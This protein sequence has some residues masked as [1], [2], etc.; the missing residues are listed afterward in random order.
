[1]EPSKVLPQQKSQIKKT[2]QATPQLADLIRAHETYHPHGKEP[3]PKP[4]PPKPLPPTGTPPYTPGKP[5]AQVSDQHSL[6]KVQSLVNFEKPKSAID[7][8]IDQWLMQRRLRGL[9]T[10]ARTRESYGGTVRDFLDFTKGVPPTLIRTPDIR[11]YLAWL[12]AQG[13]SESSVNQKTFALRDFFNFLEYIGAVPASPARL[14]KSRKIPKRL[15]KLLSIEEVDRL[16]AA[17]QAPLELAILETFYA[18]GMRLAELRTMRIENINFDGRCA[19]ILGK[20][21]KERL[22]PLTRRSLASLRAVIAGR[23]QGF[24]FQAQRRPAGNGS[25]SARRGYWILSWSERA[26]TSDGETFSRRRYKSLGTTEKEMTQVEAQAFADKFA[27]EQ[28]GH[29]LKPQEDKPISQY[30]VA[31]IVKRVGR[32]VGLKIHP[33]MLRHSFATHLHERGADIF[34]VKELLG[35]ESILTT[36]I[37]AHVSPS[38]LRETWRKFHP[39]GE[40]NEPGK[41]KSAVAGAVVS[42]APRTD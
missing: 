32:R 40:A 6:A 17:A 20:G 8:M 16:V 28:L 25:V 41:S 1:M 13:N 7:R 21:D 18:S 19:K 3:S 31:S 15:P 2:E 34:A 37:Y 39:H 33:H 22:V 29:K 26:A 38:K 36:Q 12:L 23:T 5:R 27:G 4:Q 11:E 10:S 30:G 24:V 35:H 42:H 14:I 9:S